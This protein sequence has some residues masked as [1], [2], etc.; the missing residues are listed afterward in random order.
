MTTLRIWSWKPGGAASGAALLAVAIG[1]ILAAGTCVLAHDPDPRVLPP[2]LAPM[3]KSYGDWGAAWWQWALSIPKAENPI[4]DPTG[5]LGHVGQSG[6]V[7]FLAGT[8]GGFA[9]RTCIVPA[10]KAIFFPIVDGTWWA[11]DDI[12]LAKDIA[13]MLGKNPA[14]M[15]DEE[16]IRLVVN[17]QIDHAAPIFCTVDGV[18][19]DGLE[20]YRAQ[21]SP[22]D[23]NLSDLVADWGYTPGPAGPA[24]ADGYWVML[25]PLE[26][27]PH[28]IHFKGGLTFTEPGFEGWTFT[29]EMLYHLTVDAGPNDAIL[30]PDLMV[31]GMS[32]GEWGAKWWQWAYSIPVAD[33]P[34]FDE[35]GAKAGTAQSGPVYF[36]AG[37]INVSGTA[38]RTI[39]VPAG[40]ALF[41][42][43]LNVET[44]NVGVDPPNT[45]EQLYGWADFYIRSITDI[46]ANLDG[47]PVVNAFDYRGTSPASFS[48]DLPATDNI[49]Q[50][51][52]MDISGTVDPAV[53]DGHWLMLAPLSPGRHR[54][55]FGG[56]YGDPINFTLNIIY[57]INVEDGP[58]GVVLPSDLAV[59][60]M[61][62][63]EWGAEWWQWA[64]S[65]PVTGHP[66]FDDT[67]ANAANGQSGPVWFL[68]GT[69]TVLE[70]K[71]GE[72]VGRV[73]REFTMPYGKAIFFPILNVETDSVGI[74]PPPT[75]AELAAWAATNIDHVTEVRASVD[76]VPLENLGAARA[77]SPEP[78]AF[79]LPDADNLY[80]FF[81]VDVKGTIEPAMSDGY[82]VMLKPL[83]PGEHTIKFYGKLDMSAE[84]GMIFIQDITHIVTVLPEVVAPSPLILPWQFQ[85]LGMTYAGWSA[86]WWQWAL[87]QPADVNPIEDPDGRFS[88]NGQ[89]GPVW[90]L[91]GTSGWMAERAVTIPAGKAIFF[92]II[93]NIW[94]TIPDNPNYPAAIPPSQCP[95]RRRPPV[96]HLRRLRGAWTQRTSSSA[97]SM[98]R[99]SRSRPSIAQRAR[100]SRRICP[101]MP[102]PSHRIST[103]P[104]PTRT[105]SPTGT[106]SCWRPSLRESTRSTSAGEARSRASSPK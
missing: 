103:T 29:T 18:P 105:P 44:D 104:E 87:A 45:V 64:L 56:T 95:A 26:A 1:L 6:P 30:P 12:P 10:G 106:G 38:E 24:V 15:S 21:S 13:T 85:A 48:Y 72:I 59:G 73:T 62:Y 57:H 89:S 102:G 3:G 35:T 98:A 91:A 33:N 34:L 17:W 67:G 28:E 58:N 2:N 19:I 39:T 74:D 94:I 90:F 93:N 50:Y 51:F 7:W 92:P 36:L 70:E 8:F 41:F 11:P 83:P 60:G 75:P 63:G 69:F 49:Y 65:L 76:G 97:N 82:W 52:G 14:T 84:G 23:V 5:A 101:S 42:P 43:I 79:T 27:G 80:Q 20:S 16:L 40:K 77:A 86:K 99:R 88:A 55:E 46:H 22:F 47:K 32:Y 96:R 78:F 4:L 31:G 100:C 54:L 25:A 81:G 37:V 71:P 61:T 68:G 53:S 9:E 66:L